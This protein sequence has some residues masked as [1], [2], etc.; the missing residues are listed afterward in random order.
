[1]MEDFDKRFVATNHD[2]RSRSGFHCVFECLSMVLMSIV[3]K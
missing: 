2:L 1:M 3:P